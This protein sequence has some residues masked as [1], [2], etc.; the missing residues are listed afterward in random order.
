M[1]NKINIFLVILFFILINF[2]FNSQTFRDLINTQFFGKTY[3]SDYT[4]TEYAF[5][6]FGSSLSKLFYPFK[7][8]LYLSAFGIG[9]NIFVLFYF[10]FR[11]F[12]NSTASLMMI[13][14]SSFWISSFSM[15]YLLNKMRI[16]VF[17]SFIVSLAFSYTPYLSYQIIGQFTYTMIFFFPILF[18]LAHTFITNQNKKIKLF[19]T[20]LFGIVLGSLFYTNIYYFLMSILA[21]IFYIS[22][23]FFENRKLLIGFIKNNLKYFIFF[24]LIISLL[25]FPWVYQMKM[26]SY[27]DGALITSG[28]GGAGILSADLINFITPSE[29]NPFYKSFVNFLTDR[30]IFF[31][32]YA[33]FFFNNAGRF[34]YPGLIILG[35]YFYILF[36]R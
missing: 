10:I 34:A 14:L 26:N 28:F 31:V 9:P 21:T 2:F 5:E 33:K 23:Y 12:L 4:M 25:I 18:L 3:I 15:F 29:Y 16:N 17:V 22:Y 1:K 36:F 27:L 19:S 20:S 24:G 8:D 11:L 7:N 6:N 32:K 35:V 13:G 30:S